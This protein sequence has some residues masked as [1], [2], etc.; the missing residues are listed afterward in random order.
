MIRLF[1]KV[2]NQLLSDEKYSMYILYASGE[3]ALVMV[4]ILLALQI[5]NW[6][7]H[8]KT[9][10]ELSEI[11]E[12]IHDDLALDT[13]S[14][15]RILSERMLDI[16]AQQRVI[17]AV[18]NDLAYSDQIQN[19]LGRLM[20]KRSVPLVTSGFNL[21]KESKLISMEDRILR[22]A[23]I[24]YYEQVVIRMKEEFQDDGFEFETVW[25]PYVRQNFRE[26]KFG[27][28][29]VPADWESMRD[30]PYFLNTLQ[31][32]L[33]NIN[34]TMFEMQNGLISATYILELLDR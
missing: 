3:I 10:K 7:D 9:Q 17:H 18:Q 25:L 16:Q 34:M 24:G 15:S 23:L 31:M 21:L 33:N 12:E 22:T 32:N 27:N 8:R 30:D 14:I 4:G 6:S 19:D 20:L 29:G 2:R 13:A 1:R 28:Y 11:C 5:D 26:W